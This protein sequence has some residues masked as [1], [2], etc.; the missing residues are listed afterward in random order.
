MS[1]A[2]PASPWAAAIPHAE[3]PDLSVEEASAKQCEPMASSEP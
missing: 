1:I 3:L 2:V